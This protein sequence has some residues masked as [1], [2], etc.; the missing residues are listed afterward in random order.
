MNCVKLLGLT[1][2]NNLT[3]NAHIDEVIK[4]VGKRLYF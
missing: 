2:R 1:I 3:W 4:K